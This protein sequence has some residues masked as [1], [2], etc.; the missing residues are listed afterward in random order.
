MRDGRVF[1]KGY[2]EEDSV[3]EKRSNFSY[4]QRKNADGAYTYTG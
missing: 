4:G 2:M 1:Q 3:S